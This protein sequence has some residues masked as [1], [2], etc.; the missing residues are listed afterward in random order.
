MLLA[1]RDYK[2]L[3]VDRAT[4]P[5]DAVSTHL[6]HPP[7]VAALERWDL[8]ERL[9]ASG[10]PLIDTYVFDFG[11]FVIAG[12]PGIPAAPV[13]YVPRRTIQYGKAVEAPAVAPPIS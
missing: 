3:V 8:L 7:G 13:A 9:V 5:S 1:R 10:C 6:I 12:T 2:V 4:F 11:S